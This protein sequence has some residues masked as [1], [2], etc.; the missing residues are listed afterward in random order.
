MNTELYRE[1]LRIRLL[2]PACHDPVISDSPLMCTTCNRE[3]RNSNRESR[4][5]IYEYHSLRCHRYGHF[6]KVRHDG[7]RDACYNFLRSALIDCQIDKEVNLGPSQ[8]PSIAPV[9]ADLRVTH[10]DYSTFC[11]DVSVTDCNLS[12]LINVNE[13]DLSSNV[14]KS[15]GIACERRECDKKR[16]YANSCGDQILDSFIPFVLDTTGRLGKCANS[17][18]SLSSPMMLRYTKADQDRIK[19]AKRFF[20]RRIAILNAI[21]ISRTV[22]ADR[23][24]R[25]HLHYQQMVLSTLPHQNHLNSTTNTINMTPRV[26]SLSQP[27]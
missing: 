24:H 5:P 25:K 10:P 3:S 20:L 4:T 16:K 21:C 27:Q 11:V 13:S 23:S 9:I 8:D 7:I 14:V 1:A 17:L 26:N 12:T 18:V 2:M 22:R 19:K 6:R 15:P